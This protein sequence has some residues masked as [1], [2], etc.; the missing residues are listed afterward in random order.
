MEG[1]GETGGRRRPPGEW[2][3]GLPALGHPPRGPGAPPRP[4]PPPGAGGFAALG[5]REPAAAAAPEAAPEATAAVGARL[6]AAEEAAEARQRE[7]RDIVRRAERRVQRASA[8]EKDL[9]EIIGALQDERDLVSREMRVCRQMA[10]DNF[11]AVEAR[12]TA[13]RDDVQ[14]AERVR[15]EVMEREASLLKCIERLQIERDGA[16]GEM[17]QCEH[18]P[19]P[20][21]SLRPSPHA[22]APLPP[23]PP[24]LSLF[25]CD[26]TK[27][28]DSVPQDD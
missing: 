10:Q 28:A 25:R 6:R 1:G 19:P 7:A 5:A 15:L 2:G 14:R 16:I 26:S 17:M 13:L 4:A 8:R 21:P 23:P 20:A 12:E 9:L 18:A 27:S 3:R 22:N 24:S 11:K